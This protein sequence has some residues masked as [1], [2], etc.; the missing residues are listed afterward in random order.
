M[1]DVDKLQSINVNSFFASQTMK[2]ATVAV[3]LTAMVA[4][5]T[6]PSVSILHR[7]QGKKYI[8]NSSR[9]HFGAERILFFIICFFFSLLAKVRCMFMGTF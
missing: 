6:R 7:S 1:D 4:T 8:S 5:G 3:W 9:M 2:P